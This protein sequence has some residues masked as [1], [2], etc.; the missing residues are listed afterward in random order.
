VLE[1]LPLE[2]LVLAEAVLAVLHL[3]LVVQ[4]QLTLVA[5]VVLVIQIP[6]QPLA[7]QA[8][9]SSKCQTQH[10]QNSQAV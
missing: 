3:L 10:T 7:V 2:V 8:S 4:E 5:V 1:V 6:H 9:S